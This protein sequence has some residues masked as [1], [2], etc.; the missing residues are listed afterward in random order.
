MKNILYLIKLYLDISLYKYIVVGLCVNFVNMATEITTAIADLMKHFVSTNYITFEDNKLNI[1]LYSLM[2]ILI[3]YIFKFLI[4][5]D[6]FKDQINYFKWYIRYNIIRRQHIVYL[7]NKL[8]TPYS[9]DKKITNFNELHNYELQFENATYFQYLISL[10]LS[11]NRAGS[12]GD[13][14]FAYSYNFC[15]NLN[16]INK[17]TDKYGNTISNNNENTIYEKPFMITS[18]SFQNYFISLNQ[19][20]K[21]KDTSQYFKVIAFING[22]YIFVNT[23]CFDLDSCIFIKCSNKLA[24]D[25]FMNLIQH[26]F[27]KNKT[28]FKGSSDKLK[29][30]EYDGKN[31]IIEVGFVKPNLTF[32]HYVSRHKK[33]ILDKLN[34]FKEGLLYKNNPYFENNLGLMLHGYYGSGKTFLI[35]AIAN[36]TKRD[37]YSINLVKIKTVS[38]W[39]KIMSPSNLEKYVFAIDEMD[40]VLGEL[41]LEDKKSNVGSSVD[42]SNSGSSGS[43][44]VKFKIQMLSVQISNTDD[45]K[46]KDLL[47]KE[48]KSLMEINTN[49]DKLTY[50]FLLGELS[51]LLS[52]QNRILIATTNFPDKIP[53]ALKRPGRFDILIEL[54][55][56]NNN[57]IKELL[58]K[59]YNPNK[60]DLL[61]LKNTKLPDNKY[62][63]AE[64]IMK[65]SENKNI[66][67]LIKTI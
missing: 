13:T 17:T 22:Y 24:L 3:S 2:S 1:L 23:D 38:E 46:T 8:N 55:K 27:D 21:N 61:L 67:D 42:S 34:L 66:N 41:L 64:L 53:S 57:E 19:D 9:P 4:N 54:G 20:N 25:L 49:N 26:D 63:P 58:I 11:K 16:P 30:V 65:A 36:Y 50:Q 52:T 35:S 60:E 40:Y 44:E 18:K 14:V 47:V 10:K 29:V 59:L 37:I 56:F 28:Y 15:L 43:D 33:S 62:T 39:R 5:Y 32:D 7:C 31:S 12:R 6:D 45:V 48:M 51:G